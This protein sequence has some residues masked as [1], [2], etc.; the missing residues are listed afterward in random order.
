[1]R[2]PKKNLKIA[3]YGGSGIG[4]TTVALELAKLFN[5]K[6]RLRHCGELIKCK[7]K[8]NGLRSPSCLSIQDHKT[9]DKETRLFALNTTGIIIV[10]GRYL[11]FVL[12]GIEGIFFV[13]L[14]CSS[15]QRIARLTKAGRNLGGNLIED[16]DEEDN[17]LTLKLYGDVKP[18]IKHLITVDNTLLSAI[19]SAREIVKG[20][21][22]IE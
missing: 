2:L 8:V 22:S 11:N 7:S 1:M 10:E 18:N 17:Q 20:I 14:V 6:V 19:D 13:Q 12:D 9:I 15:A 16:L 4:K 5:T 21:N 3:I